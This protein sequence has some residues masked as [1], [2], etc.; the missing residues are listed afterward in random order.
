[1]ACTPG[2][3]RW[4]TRHCLA[5]VAVLALLCGSPGTAASED[6]AGRDDALGTS[7]IL[8]VDPSTP[9]LG[10]KHFPKTLP[11]EDKE[12]VLTFDD[13]PRPPTT[14]KILDAL[15]HECVRATFFMVGEM[16]AGAPEM[17][18]RVLAEGHT[19][20]HHTYRHPL[21]NRMRPDAAMGEIDHGIAA[22][23]NA[24]YGKTDGTAK[25]PFFRFPGFASSPALLDRLTDRGIIVFGA[26]FWASDWNRM[27]P[28]QE[29][30][31]IMKRL[32]EAGG[33]ILVM[34]DTKRN[35]AA[36]LPALLRR[37]KARGFKIVHVVPVAAATP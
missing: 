22:V 11:L 32:S 18:K 16:A 14:G 21:L 12:V 9:R 36:M 23:E 30:R 5:V 31:L 6:C 4:Q 8:T 27:R 29:L 37:M 10:R 15:K 28:E 2:I 20:A 7:R 19:V 34:H 3:S 25:T 26:D 24:L 33:G 17:A 1:M 13:G 35:T